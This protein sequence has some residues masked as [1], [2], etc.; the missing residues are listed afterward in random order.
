MR[1]RVGVRAAGPRLRRGGNDPVRAENPLVTRVHLSAL[2]LIKARV[3][4]G[5][6][7]ELFAAKGSALSG[8]VTPGYSTVRAPIVR[9]II[10]KFPHLRVVFIARDPVERLW[11]ALAMRV[12]TGRID[13]EL[14]ER[15]INKQ[16][17]GHL[18]AR[19]YQTKIVS[20]WRRIVPETQFRLF[21]FDDLLRDASEFRSRV[22]T[23]LGGDPEKPSGALSADYN[24]KSGAGKPP[25][26][27]DMRA[28]IGE[29]LADELRASATE[30]G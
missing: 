20:R 12:R 15:T 5:D 27:D 21:L 6:Y 30:F 11:S 10:K 26:T 4:Y 28:F 2:R 13:E 19:S 18:R 9:R 23:F 25:L 7:A 17:R 14:D 16:W 22:V 8:D 3:G 24:R 1:K 29:L